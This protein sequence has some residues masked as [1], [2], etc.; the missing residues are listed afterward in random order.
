MKKRILT[1]AL[2]VLL[3]VS[4]LPASVGVAA[5][6]LSFVALND[7]LPPDLINTPVYYGGTAYLPY[8]FFTNY[9][10]GINYSYLSSSSTAYLF[11]AKNQVFFELT[12]GKTYNSNDVQ[13]DAP[14]IFWGG[15]VYLPLGFMSTAFG[16]FTYRNI[17]QNE[18][19]SIL[20]IT[21]GSQILGDDDFFQAAQ[22]AMRRYYQAYN[23]SDNPTQDHTPASPEPTENP[24]PREG[25]VIRLGLEGMP[26]AEVLELLEREGITACF[27]LRADE[28]RS[29]PD[30]V[31]RI[32]CTGHGL[33]AS[34][35]GG[36]AAEIEETAALLWE[37][38]RVRTI[39][40]TLP[41][42]AV[43]PDGIV[44]FPASGTELTSEELRERVYLV[45]TELEMRSGDQTLLFPTGDGDTAA[46]RM[47]LYYLDEQGF[48]I[49]P[50]REPDG[51]ETPIT[52]K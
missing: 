43:V 35:P 12:S 18:Y 13:Y 3:L 45:T 2:C 17:G 6:P 22:G 27:F 26:T 10:F 24:Q 7:T 23:A 52:L 47:L 46:L 51:A 20:R 16:G 37:A 42:G 14:A 36:S 25:D 4:L 31:R 33:G 11:N 19:G 15:T 40:Y 39:L 41:E 38:A 34:C 30:T 44:A 5:N 50:L 9:G 29:D 49:T 8:W 32:A 48:L 28:I 21:T 1:L